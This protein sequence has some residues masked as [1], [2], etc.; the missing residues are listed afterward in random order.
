[1]RQEVLH[2]LRANPELRDFMRQNPNWYRRISRH[3]EQFPVME[4]EAKYFYGR[5]FSQRVEKMQNNV[6]MAMMLMEMLK[7]GGTTVTDT[8]QSMRSE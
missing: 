7:M 4:Q 5:T 3:P 1:M 8:V 2:Q 6:S